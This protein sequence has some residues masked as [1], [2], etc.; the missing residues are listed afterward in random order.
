V[1][2]APAESPCV[3]SIHKRLSMHFTCVVNVMLPHEFSCYVR[4]ITLKCICEGSSLV[5]DDHGIDMA[6]RQIRQPATLIFLSHNRFMPEC[7]AC[8][9]LQTYHIFAAINCILFALRYWHDFGW[10][11][12]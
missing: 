4:R 2:V 6:D 5:W 9:R 11:D 1:A 10:C 8:N 12:C 7:V 3:C